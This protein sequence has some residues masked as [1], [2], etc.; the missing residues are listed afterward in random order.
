MG[1]LLVF[2]PCPLS[3][4]RSYSSHSLWMKQRILNLPPATCLLGLR[5]SFIPLVFSLVGFSQLGSFGFLPSAPGR[6]GHELRFID[7]FPKSSRVAFTEV[8]PCI[9]C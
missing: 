6:G 2:S 8:K 7:N 1:H 4:P 5:L 9:E 3:S